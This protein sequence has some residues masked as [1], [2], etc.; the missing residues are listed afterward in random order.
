C[1]DS[2]FSFISTLKFDI[3]VVDLM[4]QNDVEILL[5]LIAGRDLSNAELSLEWIG[6]RSSIESVRRTLMGMPQVAQLTITWRW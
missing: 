3:L 1:I 4:A 6:A 5:P 2:L